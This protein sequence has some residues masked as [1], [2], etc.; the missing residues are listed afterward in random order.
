MIIRI[1]GFAILVLFPVVCFAQTE[2]VVIKGTPIIQNKS[3]V[4]ES[5][6]FQ[7]SESQQT[8]SRLIIT[9]KGQNITGRAAKIESLPSMK[10]ESTLFFSK[11][12]V[13]VT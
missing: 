2:V 1:L 11:Q 13:L 8:E 4:E 5:A 9:R 6:N 10:V 12:R 7:L 3:S